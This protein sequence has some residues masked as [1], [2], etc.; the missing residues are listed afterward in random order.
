MATLRII[1]LAALGSLSFLV[2]GCAST[3]P[4][5][6]TAV[7]VG[8]SRGVQPRELSQATVE[9]V[10]WPMAE[11]C[12]NGSPKSPATKNYCMAA[13]NLARTSGKDE[14]LAEKLEN[15]ARMLAENSRTGADSR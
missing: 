13:A 11:R 8:P 7:A 1:A 15:S 4:G 10:F 2:F 12:L 9:R 14:Q 6:A 3:T 5:A